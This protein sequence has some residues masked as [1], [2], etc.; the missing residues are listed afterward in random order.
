MLPSS[1]LFHW[2]AVAKHVL[3]PLL[4]LVV[5][6]I[7]AQEYQQQ[8][9]RFLGRALALVQLENNKTQAA[10]AVAFN[11]HCASPDFPLN[12]LVLIDFPVQSS[13]TG[14]RSAKLDRFF[15]GSFQI[16]KARSPDCFNVLELQTN[17]KWYNIHTS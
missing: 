10:N 9:K 1:R 12:D 4:T 8:V 7:P 15:H 17:K 3:L 6:L 11:S 16:T 2:S 14:K 13:A 5:Q